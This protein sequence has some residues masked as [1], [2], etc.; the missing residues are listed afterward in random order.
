MELRNIKAVI[1]DWAG[2]MVDFGSMAPTKVLI[3]LFAD[4]KIIISIDLAR[5]FMG[6]EKKL[7]VRSILFSEEVQ[8]Q[9]IELY[10]RI[11][12]DEDLEILFGKMNSKL[13]EILHNHADVI[14][15]VFDFTDM[16]KQNG[17]KLGSTTGY[18]KDMM[19]VLSPA[20]LD[21]GFCPDCMVCPSDINNVGRPAP[22]MIYENMR[23]LDVYPA[24]K[25]VKLGDTVADI[26]EGLNAGMWVIVFTLSG[27]ECGLTK[28][29]LKHCSDMQIREIRDNAYAKFKN[30]GAHFI[31]DGVW[32]VNEALLEVDNLIAKG[33]CPNHYTIEL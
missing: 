23:K 17:I 13:V 11:P 21:N 1:T 18:V 19:D 22:F 33:I 24:N 3:E 26:S 25:M 6:M 16:L 7:H 8:N 28:E 5:K 10:G 32:D 15:G 9:W 20:A 12:N 29:E 30:A 27:N 4:S 2:T 31:C 14:P